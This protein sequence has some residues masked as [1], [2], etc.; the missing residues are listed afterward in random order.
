MSRVLNA[1]FHHVYQLALLSSEL[2]EIFSRAPPILGNSL[3]DEAGSEKKRRPVEGD[4]PICFSEL[5]PASNEAIVWCKAACGQN[6]H[7]ECFETWATTKRQSGSYAGRGEVTCPMCRT[8]WEGDEDL[9][10]RAKKSEGK[11]NSDGYV[12]VGDQLGVSPV[13]G[14]MFYLFIQDRTQ[15]LT[16]GRHQH[17]L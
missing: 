3:A 14:K 7:K 10:K 6:M 16:I 12:N 15:P 11:V 9:V 4:C 2:Q 5:D 1:P 17:I 8:K 13:R